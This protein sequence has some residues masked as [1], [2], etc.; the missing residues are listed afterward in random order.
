MHRINHLHLEQ[1][2]GLKINDES[3][4]GY[5][6]GS[7]I[8]F[9]TTMLRSSLCDYADAYILVKETITIT[10]VGNDVAAIWLDERNK[11]VIFKN[12]APFT[13]CIS[14]MNDTEIDDAQDID[15]VMPMYN[16]IEYSDNY[17]KASGSLWQYYKDGPNDNIA[18]SESSKSKVKITE[19][20]PVGGNTKDFKTIVPLKHLS[21]FWRILEI[22]FI[23]CE[24][25]LFLTWSSTC[26]ITNST[27][28]EKWNEM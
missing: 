19:N 14:K 24:V 20:T 15:T 18:N 6:T 17:S 22:P 23:D 4:R 26:V 21:N 8:K 9:K 27:G 11:S 7:D 25:S 16:L 13:K 3:R 10:G 12:C 2:L 1:K 5:T 28:E